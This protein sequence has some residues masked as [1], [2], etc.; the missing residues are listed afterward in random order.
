MLLQSHLDGIDILPALPDGIP[1]GH[2]K[3]I[4]ARGGFDLE[5]EW[6]GGKLKKLKVTSFSGS[7]LLI[8]YADKEFRSETSVG[9]VLT[10]DGNLVK[11]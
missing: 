1:E 8:R 3:G 7:P 4:R 5:F 6:S 10:F 11:L 2:V 9:Q